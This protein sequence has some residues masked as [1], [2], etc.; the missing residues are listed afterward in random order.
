MKILVINKYLFKKGGDAISSLATG[1]LLASKG[2]EVVFWGMADSQNPSYPYENIFIKNIDFNAQKNIKDKI[3]VSLNVLYS[4]EAKHKIEKLITLERPDIVHLNN[5]A[6]QISPSILHIFKK[7]N[8]PCVMT[9]HDY[10]MVCPTYSMLLNGKPCEKCKGGKYYQCFINRCTK[11]SYAKSLLNTAEM[12]LHHNVLHIYDIVDTFISPSMFLKLK[13]K[14]MGFEREVE[15]LPNFVENRQFVPFYNWEERSV[16]YFGRL[17]Q[18]KGLLTLT[19][20]VKGVGVKLKIIG[21]GPLKKTLDA[22][23]K[24]EDIKNVYFLGYQTGEALMGEIRKSMFVVLPS[25]CYENNPR[26]IIEGFALG[27]PALGA[28]IGGIP[29]LVKDNVTGL[30]FEAGNVDDLKRKIEQLLNSPDKI[31]EMGKNARKYVEDNLSPDKHY[32]KLMQI[33]QDAIKKHKKCE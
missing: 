33:Y 29:E 11:N 5:F 9:M 3:L 18:E 14:E 32:E 22:K 10:K 16:V 7:C 20:A 4:L 31:I 19:D 15:Y 13:C 26:S 27:K 21:E 30:T 2:H 6:H 17:S 8:I 28:R 1:C 25:E 24:D 12:Y 23:V